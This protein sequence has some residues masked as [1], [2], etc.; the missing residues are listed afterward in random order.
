MSLFP[1][2]LSGSQLQPRLASLIR[3]GLLLD[4]R[5]KNA[6]DAPIPDA[7]GACSPAEEVAY[8]CWKQ[9]RR[10]ERLEDAIQ[11]APASMSNAF[12]RRIEYPANRFNQ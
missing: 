3:L 8:I 4:T 7:L 9:Q 10:R 6:P 11:P 5:T 2:Q 1:L 12:F